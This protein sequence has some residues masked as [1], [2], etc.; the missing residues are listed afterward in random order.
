MNTS[1]GNII[2]QKW[3]TNE[4]FPQPTFVFILK[5]DLNKKLLI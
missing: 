2:S 3:I 4:F 1:T 5:S